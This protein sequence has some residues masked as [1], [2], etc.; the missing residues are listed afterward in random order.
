VTGQ[1]S[2]QPVADEAAARLRTA[3]GSLQDSGQAG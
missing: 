3:L 1:R 2:L